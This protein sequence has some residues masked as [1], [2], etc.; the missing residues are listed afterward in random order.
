VSGA[1]GAAIAYLLLRAGLPEYQLYG[2]AW[3]T[4]VCIIVS[5]VGAAYEPYRKGARLVARIVKAGHAV[6][7]VVCLLLAESRG[8]YGLGLLETTLL[9]EMQVLFIALSI[10]WSILIVCAVL[11]AFVGMFVKS[12]GDQ[13]A[14]ARSNAAIRTG[15]QTLALSSGAFLAVLIF[16]WSG[17]FAFG[18]DKLH[19]YECL[20]PTSI[21]GAVEGPAEF[22]RFLRQTP[23]T[24][25][26]RRCSERA[27]H[28][29]MVP[30]PPS[31]VP[32]Q[33]GTSQNYF[34]GWLVVSVS[35]GAPIALGIAAMAF[36]MLLWM[37]IP[38]VRSEGMPPRRCTNQESLR[39][40]RWLSRGLD[41]TSVVA[42]LLTIAVFI[43]PLMFA[44]LDSM[45]RRG[46]SYGSVTPYLEALTNGTA[47]LLTTSGAFLVAFGALLVTGIAKVGGAALDVVLDV[48]NYL[49]TTPEDGPP[50]AKIS[51]RYVSL[52]RHLASDDEHGNPRYAGIVIVAHSLGAL[53]TVEQLRF[54]Q[55]A[56]SAGGDPELANLGFGPKGNAVQRTRLALFT[57]GNPLRQLINRFFPHR[58]RWVREEPDNGASPMADAVPD[59]IP[60]LPTI[61]LPDPSRLN[62]VR[63]D[64][65]YRSG[66]YVGRAMWL[67][68]WFCRNT[69]GADGGNPP[70]RP[71]F[72]GQPRFGEMCIGSGAH[73]HYW[74]DTAPDV[75]RHVDYL[76]ATM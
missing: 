59:D 43:V 39:M 67:D 61:V 26:V 17:I 10:L 18:R 40:G 12:T 6:A 34:T 27:T 31:D 62:V 22:T 9:W 2:A 19:V 64:N 76:I 8:W 46:V 69:E 37:A 20:T 11:A 5:L 66:D 56:V 36:F 57:M 7:Y 71:S 68:E 15:R 24:A 48:D 55:A 50:R 51:E 74:D 52:L 73:T 53:I 54:L 35:T 33:P 25:A 13:A 3:T 58:Y 65:A 47:S 72:L 70:S 49:R 14:N 1:A 28:G 4:L 23:D 29:D 45:R 75:A 63:W 16:I 42:G 38:S 21:A 30:W 41:A 44:L 32:Y 60:Q